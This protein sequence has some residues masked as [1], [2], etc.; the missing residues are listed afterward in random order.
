MENPAYNVQEAMAIAPQPRQAQVPKAVRKPQVPVVKTVQA[1][2][3]PP[4]N[5]TPAYAMAQKPKEAAYDTGK[6][7]V[8]AGALAPERL[9]CRSCGRPA[10]LHLADPLLLFAAL[11]VHSQPF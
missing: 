6:G 1:P 3:E 4:V 8:P 9:L 5:A 10:P 2:V 11:C 7:R